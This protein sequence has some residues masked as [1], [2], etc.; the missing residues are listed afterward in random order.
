ML[1]DPVYYINQYPDIES[2]T[3]NSLTPY[4][5]AFQ[6][7]INNGHLECRNP[8]I[9]FNHEYYVNKYADIATFV[10]NGGNA[11]VHFINWGYKENRSP[12]QYFD[13][14]FYYD[15]YPDIVNAGINA[16]VHFIN[17]GIF[18]GRKTCKGDFKYKPMER[19]YSLETLRYYISNKE[20]FGAINKYAEIYQLGMELYISNSTMQDINRKL[21]KS[22]KQITKLNGQLVHLNDLNDLTDNVKTVY[23]CHE[24]NK[25][26][27]KQI[28]DL[29][30]KVKILTQLLRRQI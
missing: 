15:T 10:K 13:P 14:Q 7:F 28:I 21:L 9:W 25:I 29:N 2:H 4:Y 1:I 27:N 18:E 16:F 12:S 11:F 17:W 20:Q 24:G 19:F 30:K 3:R 5:I 8:S 22:N 6:H 26:I 23:L